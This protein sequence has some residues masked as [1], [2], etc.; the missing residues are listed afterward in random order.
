VLFDVANDCMFQNAGGANLSLLDVIDAG[1]CNCERIP[2]AYS[3]ACNATPT[4]S[5]LPARALYELL[6]SSPGKLSDWLE[7]IVQIPMIG[8]CVFLPTGT[9]SRQSYVEDL[10]YTVQTRAAF[11]AQNYP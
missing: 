10:G 3:G 9:E 5:A 6:L 7:R 1:I 4:S 11:I 8:G 2:L